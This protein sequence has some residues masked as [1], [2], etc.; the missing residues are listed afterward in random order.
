[1]TEPSRK[2]WSADD[3]PSQSGRTV[4]ITGANSGLGAETAKALARH[5]AKVVL[6]CRNTAKADDVAAAIG[7]AATVRDLDSVRAF[8]DTVDGADVLIN[9]AGIMAVPLRR[10]AQGFE[11]QM[12]TNHLGHFAL[13][14]LLLPKI[15]DRVVTLSSGMHLLGRINLGDLNWQRRVYR[16]WQAYGDSKMANLMFG[17]ELAKRLRDAGSDK[18]SFIAHPGI[19]STSLTGHTE[20]IYGPLMKLT[21]LPIGQ[22]SA[23]GALPTLLAATTP[24]ARSG[25]FFGPKLLFGLRGAPVKSGYAGR[26]KDKAIREGLWRESER[27]TGITFSV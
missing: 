17:L 4:I 26:A 13:T 3:I 19:A 25:T 16:R 5:G 20:S 22:S 23:D 27:L 14:A 18:K 1:M 12:G 15:T 10:T 21:V 2:P 7:A 11:S 8:A 9:N 24:D 6:A